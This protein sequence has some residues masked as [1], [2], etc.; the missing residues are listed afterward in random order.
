M[1]LKKLNRLIIIMN[2][3]KNLNVLTFYWADRLATVGEITLFICII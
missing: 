2:H 1:C 3:R